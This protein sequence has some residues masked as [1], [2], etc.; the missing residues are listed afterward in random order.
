MEE[1]KEVEMTEEE[2]QK[3][4]E[5]LDEETKKEF[6]NGKGDEENE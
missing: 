6:T 1:K 5:S 4:F 2:L 3:I